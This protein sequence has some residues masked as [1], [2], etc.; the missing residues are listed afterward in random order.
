MRST[1]CQNCF[2]R[3]IFETVKEILY[4]SYPFSLLVILKFSTTQCLFDSCHPCHRDS[5]LG[6]GFYGK[7]GDVWEY[8]GRGEVMWSKEGR[9]VQ[10]TGT[11]K[12]FHSKQK[13]REVEESKWINSESNFD[14]D[15][16]LE[17]QKWFLSSQVIS[18]IASASYINCH[19]EVSKL[20]KAITAYRAAPKYFP[21]Q[22]Q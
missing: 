9:R 1:I 5:H 12:T 20:F 21:L 13:K 8:A 10:K 16:L 15:F 11:H 22:R 6:H 2:I 3:F 4:I 18:S 19:S 17:L 14:S 7:G